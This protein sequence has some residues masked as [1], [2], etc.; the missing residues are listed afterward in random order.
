V[1]AS[2]VP[3]ANS[4]LIAAGAVSPY[5][6]VEDKE[7]KY[8]GWY[9]FQLQDPFSATARLHIDGKRRSVYLTLSGIRLKF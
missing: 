5:D 6:A 2:E 7:E 9:I 8:R 3:W 4:R 1:N